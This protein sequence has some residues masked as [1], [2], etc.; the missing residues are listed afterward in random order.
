MVLTI[1]LTHLSTGGLTPS[2]WFAVSRLSR[3]LMT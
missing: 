3:Y 2:F 1:Q